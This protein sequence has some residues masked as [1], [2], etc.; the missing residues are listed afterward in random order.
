[1]SKETNP[2]ATKADI[3]QLNTDVTQVRSD[4]SQIKADVNQLASKL[5]VLIGSLDDFA[6]DTDR[7]FK[8]LFDDVDNI[9]SI[10]GSIDDRLTPQ[11]RDHERRISRLEK[12]AGLVT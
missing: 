1:M 9:V 4:V 10:L 7:R 11:A 5:D 3:T 6:R 8:V 2:P 12:K